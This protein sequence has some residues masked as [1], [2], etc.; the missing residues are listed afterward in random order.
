VSDRCILCSRPLDL[1]NTSGICAECTLLV[2]NL[3]EVQIDERW[4]PAAG[5]DAVIVSD[6]ARVARLLTID[7]SHR[8]PRVSIGVGSTTCARWSPK[9]SSDP[10]R[11][12]SSSCT[13][14]TTPTIRHRRI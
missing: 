11:T 13:A 2:A 9:R 3:L 1:C 5:T 12:A 10:A 6:R 7:H 8:Y 4:R 14:M